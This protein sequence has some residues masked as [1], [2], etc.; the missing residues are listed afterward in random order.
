MIIGS[1]ESVTEFNGTTEIP[2]FGKF[3]EAHLTT[4]KVTGVLKGEFVGETLELVHCRLREGVGGVRNGP[5][6]A[7]FESTGRTI[8]IESGGN[9]GTLVQE[10]QPSYLPFLKRR[11]DGRYEPVAGQVDSELSV[12][13]LT[14][15]FG[16]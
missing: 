2:Q 12:R 10:S 6:L 1:V 15:A 8:R 14:T 16:F 3:L 5:L 13:K 4:F 9:A 7:R 11:D